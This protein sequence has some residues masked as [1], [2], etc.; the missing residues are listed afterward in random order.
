MVE[1]TAGFLASNVS[2]IRQQH[3]L[4]CA[5]VVAK[6]LHRI[7][8][9]EKHRSFQSSLADSISVLLDKRSTLARLI[10]LLR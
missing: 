6:L 10:L 5:A 7:L 9:S 1:E 8:L 4:S 3:D 2:T